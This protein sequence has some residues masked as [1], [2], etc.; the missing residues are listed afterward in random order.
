MLL[1]IFNKLINNKENKEVQNFIQELSEKVDS[2]KNNMQNNPRKEKSVIQ[3]LIEENK[4]TTSYRDKMH[5]E[6]AHILNGYAEQTADKGTMYYI[7]NKDKDEEDTYHLNICDKENSHK[8]IKVKESRLPAGSGVDSVLRMENGKYVLDIEAT[9]EV[10]KKMEIMTEKLLE[11]Q[12]KE[13][14]KNRIEGHSY[15]VVEVSN[16]NVTL[17]DI[18]KDANNGECFEEIVNSKENFQNAKEGDVFQYVD[19]EYVRHYNK[20]N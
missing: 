2:P 3:E 19:G 5:V 15:E 6:R 11:E 10:C 14:D 4:L 1:N 20:N 12:T 9:N 13:I 18:T 7:F 17:L 8:V 16:K